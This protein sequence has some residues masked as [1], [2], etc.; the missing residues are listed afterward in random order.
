MEIFHRPAVRV[1]CFDADG[2][3][4][5]MNWRD[6]HDGS[7]LWE[8]PG[9]GI[10]EGESPLETARRELAEETGLDPSR[11]GETYIDV[12]RASQWKGRLYTGNEQF[13]AARYDTARPALSAA[14]L[15]PY[16]AEELL[17]HAWIAPADFPALPDRL[18]PPHLAEVVARL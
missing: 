10:E 7:R 8:P 4:L 9:G 15:M 11:V 14:G 2:R 18:E 6:P 3:V 5:L 17:G 16:E 12:H 13:F 1:I